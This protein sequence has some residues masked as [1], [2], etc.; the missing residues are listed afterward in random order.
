M[1]TDRQE[2]YCSLDPLNR[3]SNIQ[4]RPFLQI[5]KKVCQGYDIHAVHIDSTIRQI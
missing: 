1:T 5:E 3:I 4:F 2:I